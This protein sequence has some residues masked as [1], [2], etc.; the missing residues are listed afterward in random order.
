MGR[1][2][3]LKLGMWIFLL[4]DAFSFGGLL[5][6]LRRAARA[7]A[8]RWW[9]AGEPRAGHQLH[10]RADLPADL[11][12]R[13]HGA[14]GGR[15]PREGQR[16]QTARLPGADLAGR[17]C[18]SCWARYHEYFGIGGAGPARAGAACSGGSHRATTFYVITSFHGFHVLTGR[19]RCWL[20]MLVRTLRGSARR[21]RRRHRERRAVLALRRPGLDPGVH[22][23]LPDPA[24]AGERPMSHR[25]RVRAGAV[26]ARVRR[27]DAC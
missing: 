7:A 24:A 20:V 6:G 14:G 11:L 4:S 27:A 19:G 23:R 9:P 18:C 13:D 1:A 2:S 15:R 26:P 22:L 8:S 10:R 21:P 16:R 5:L 25:V 17:R 3:A 12:E